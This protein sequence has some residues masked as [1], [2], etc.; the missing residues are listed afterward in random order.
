MSWIV[1]KLHGAKGR[2]N[3]LSQPY[4]DNKIDRRIRR[5]RKAGEKI[6]VVFVCHRP[7]VWGSMK[8]VY[9][10][11]AE[12][13]AF[14]VLMVTVPQ[15][16]DD[17]PNGYI[18]E[19][20]DE[21]FAEYH[22]I[23]GFNPE[24]KTYYPLKKLKPD[25]V[26]FQQPYNC[27]R[28][29]SYWS[30]R[31]RK[32]AKIAYICYFS[33]LADAVRDKDVLASCYPLDF[34]KDVSYFFAQNQSEADFVRALFHDQLPRNLH[35][36]VTG[37]PKYDEMRGGHPEN[38]TV[39]NYPKDETHFRILW[40]PRWTTNENACHFFAYKDKFAEYCGEH[41]DVDFVFRPHPQTW[42]EFQNTGEF[43]DTQRL[44]LEEQY[45]QAPNMAID[46]SSEYI[47][48]FFSS[49]CLISD[50]SSMIVQY[51]ITGK[52]IIMCDSPASTNRYDKDGAF[53]RNLYW[54]ETWDE[55]ECFLEMLGRGEDPLM[56]S[57]LLARWELFHMDSGTT[58]GD[59]VRDA[60]AIS[61]LNG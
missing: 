4:Y 24:T 5:K 49:D 45:A 38:S 26:F 60:L 46:N 50:T 16:C 51:F 10:A 28:E 52:P 58:A 55:V 19:G 44:E 41:T 32:Y 20:A 48:T 59:M 57:R 35:I 21:F 36:I 30:Y 54:A 8:T 40:T 39:W 18:D 11:L 6:R 37:Y 2:L 15:R 17:D 61:V 33:V 27:M 47:G 23:R 53:G 14:E 7:N 12:D 31:V 22:P 43:T 42:I 25:V 13:P 34:M 29:K 3:V 1:E 56:E 9:Q